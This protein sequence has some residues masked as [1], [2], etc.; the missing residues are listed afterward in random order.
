MNN[1]KQKKTKKKI[2]KYLGISVKTVQ[3]GRDGGWPANDKQGIGETFLRSN[4]KRHNCL[5][6]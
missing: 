3:L 6:S 4:T 1:G 5:V 2:G